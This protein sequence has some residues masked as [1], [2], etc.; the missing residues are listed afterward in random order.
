MH[1]CCVFLFA[2]L[3][4]TYYFLLRLHTAFP[5]STFTADATK[6][7]SVASTAALISAW[8]THCSSNISELRGQDPP[9]FDLFSGPKAIWVRNEL[10][11][12][13]DMQYMAHDPT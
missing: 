8:A 13:L 4:L 2:L 9:G 6:L 11:M 10:S 5:P 12:L 1:V 7:S 3:A